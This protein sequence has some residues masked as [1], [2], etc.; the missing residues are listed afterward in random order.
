MKSRL[1]LLICCLALIGSVQWGGATTQTHA[2]AE[3]TPAPPIPGAR[4]SEPQEPEAPAWGSLKS[5]PATALADA[6]AWVASQPATTPRT[7]A[8][9]PAQNLPRKTHLPLVQTGGRPQQPQPPTPSIR[10]D[11]FS[12]ASLDTSVWSFQDA[13]GD[14]SM[15]MNGAEMVISVPTGRSHDIWEGENLAPR[16][17][18]QADNTDFEVEVKYETAP[19]GTYANQGIIVQADAQHFLRFDF[20]SNG[21]S[22]SIFAASFAGGKPTTRGNTRIDG[23]A[24]LYMRIKRVGNTWAQTYSR[25]GANWAP[26]ATFDAQLN[27]S[28]VGVFVGN[29]GKNPPA[30]SGRIDYFFNTAAPITPGDNPPPITPT[31]TSPAPTPTS[32]P[33]PLPSTIRS[34]DFNAT[35]LNNGIWQFQNPSGDGEV[36]MNGTNALLV[37]RAGTS[38]QG[39][40]L[41]E[42]E[43]RAPRMMQPA[44]NSDFEMEVKFET[45]PTVNFADQGII[46][47]Q[48]S[49]NFLRLDFYAKKPN[50]TTTELYVFAAQ[51]K[52][53]K[54]RTPV[55]VNSKINIG[56]PLL[57]RVKRTGDSWTQSYSLDGQNWTVSATFTAQLNVTAVGVYAGNSKGSPAYTASVDYVF[58]TAAPITPE[59]PNPALNKTPP[60]IYDFTYNKSATAIQVSWKTDKEAVGKAQFGATADY[61]L[62]AAQSTGSGYMH[63]VTLS[64]LQP[65]T[66]YHFRATATDAGGNAGATPNQ[67]VRTDAADSNAPVIDVWHGDTQTFGQRGK[68][69]RW[70]NILGRVTDPD[71]VAQLTYAINGGAA[72]P[73][74]IGPD[75]VRLANLGDFN[76]DIDFAE[77]QAGDNTVTFTAADKLGNTAT[78]QVTVV[79]QLTAEKQWPLPFTLDWRAAANI[80]D[81]VQVVDGLWAKDG[82]GVR[83][84]EPGYDRLI[85]IGD[86]VWKDYEVTVPFVVHRAAPDGGAAVG[87]VLRWQGHYQWNRVPLQPAWGWFPLGAIGVYGPNESKTSYAT[88][89]YIEGN[90]PKQIGTNKPTKLETGVRYVMKMRVTSNPSGPSNYALKVWRDGTPEPNAWDVSGAGLAGELNTGSLLILAH[91]VDASFGNVT[92]VEV[93]G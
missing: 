24:P 43:D 61:E 55:F 53:G 37:V 90:G 47:Q 75:K 26:G 20:Y 10:S 12:G 92:V 68:P 19:S 23:P 87:I 85:G 77:L 21:S 48:D 4:R 25:D 93:G 69:Q 31:P 14:S 74:G 32:T 45:V 81:A 30:Y 38:T 89:L 11:D 79:N 49:K 57:M 6:P 67:I 44:N 36:R 3:P 86:V 63:S 42:N 73:M 82:E 8:I 34:D 15:Q 22:L 62:G 70:V 1:L 17:M 28:A 46:I 29:S 18:Q 33:P 40:G 91:F 66:T 54:A 50:A 16:L 52:N 59:D 84:V 83:T 65:T 64:P 5:D 39:H 78:K 71:G 7:N 80:Q 13:A 2:Q 88:G 58:N 72:K 56:L 27:V 76:A 9:A 60:T 51:I 35:A 41:W